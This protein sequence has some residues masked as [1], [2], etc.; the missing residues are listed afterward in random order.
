VNNTVG[1]AVSRIREFASIVSREAALLVRN[2]FSFRDLA[3]AEMRKYRR[4]RLVDMAG[5]LVSGVDT[6]RYRRWGPPAVR[7]QLFDVQERR[8]VMDFVTEGDDRSFHVLNAVSPAF[9][10]GL[11]FADYVVERI[12]NLVQ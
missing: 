5:R 4:G 6:R 11:P 8:S 9:T 7:A 2:D 3:L 1:P 12:A 10:C